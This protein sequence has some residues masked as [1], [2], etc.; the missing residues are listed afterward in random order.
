MRRLAFAVGMLAN[1]IA[2][3]AFIAWLCAATEHTMSVAHAGVPAGPTVRDDASS[4]DAWEKALREAG[5]QLSREKSARDSAERSAREMRDQLAREK[6]A[7]EQADR[8]VAEARDQLERERRTKS[9]A[10]SNSLI[11]SRVATAACS[12]FW[13]A[14]RSSLAAGSAADFARRSRSS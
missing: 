10:R 5:D 1:A 4:R 11:R 2:T 9:A 7:K 12:A 8:A 14:A 3:T 13:R 6:K